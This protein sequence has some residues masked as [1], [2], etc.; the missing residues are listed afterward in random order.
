[1]QPSTT[2]PARIAVANM[3]SPRWR[4]LIR[5]GGKLYLIGVPDRP[6]KPQRSRTETAITINSMHA[7]LFRERQLDLDK[8]CQHHIQVV[9][10]ARRN[11]CPWRPSIREAS[12]V[13]KLGFNYEGFVHPDHFDYSSH[14]SGY[15]HSIA[16]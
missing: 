4:T 10:L 13:G 5:G 6:L 11:R 9:Q 2:M 12:V 3:R 7:R 16:L 15:G 8:C 14:T 1:M